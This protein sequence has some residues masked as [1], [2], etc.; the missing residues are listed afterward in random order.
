[1]GVGFDIPA[2]TAKSVVAQ[3]KDKG[4]VVRGWL[5]VQIQPVTADIADSL[6]M[7]TVEGALVAEPQLDSPAAKAGIKSGDVITA[8]DGVTIK[9][10]HDLAKKIAE[11]AP[12]TSVNLA[13]L[14]NGKQES[15][16]LTLGQLLEQRLAQ[17]QSDEN[18]NTG[19]PRLGLTLAPATDVAGAAGKGVVVTGVDPNGPAAEHGFQ[20]G[21]IIL[22]VGGKAVS[23]PVDVRNT[24]SELRKEGKH[25]VLMRVK[26]ADATKFVA[27]PLNQG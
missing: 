6:G 11:M 20:T 1:M 9:N 12:G 8:V 2:D 23:N 15:M 27:L 17:A 19:V 18:D 24:L 3:L 16:T 14:R 4:H 13:I 22:D 26:S 25:T 21:D 10:A 5:G 7:K